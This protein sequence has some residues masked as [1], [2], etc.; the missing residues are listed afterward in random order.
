MDARGSRKVKIDFAA[1]KHRHEGFFCVDAVEHPK[2]SRKLDL[3]H[4]LQF[5]KD[6]LVNPLPLPDGCADYLQAMHLIEHVT[7]W[8]APAVIGEFRRLLKLGGTLV[9]ELP[10]L[11]LACKN[12]LAGMNDQFTMWPLYGDPGH[13]DHFI[14]HRWGYTPKTIKALLQAGGFDYVKVLPPVTHGAKLTRDMR[15]E[16]IRT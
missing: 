11:E 10:N 4:A 7:A 14:T 3:V 1:G 8:E 9:L 16:A 12:L 5:D 15:A 13:K 2:A 6:R